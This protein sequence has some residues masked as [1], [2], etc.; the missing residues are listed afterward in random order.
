M[1]K[2][3]LSLAVAATLT[4]LVLPLAAPAATVDELAAQLEAMQA[5]ML[6]MQKEIKTLRAREA[7]SPQ[8]EVVETDYGEL[9]EE[10]MVL[11]EDVDDLDDRLMEPEKH[12][13][14]DRITWGG[15]FRFQAHGIKSQIPDY[16]DGMQMQ[17]QFVGALQGFGLLGEDFT[18]E[19][20]NAAVQQV[21][22]NFPPEVVDGM[23]QQFA[24]NAYQDGYDFDNDLIR[25]SRL[26]LDMDA[27]VGK[28]VKFFGRLG[29]YKVW[30]DSTGVQVFNGQPTSINWDGT[31]SSYPNSD[32]MIHVDRA[33][34]TW[35][36]IAGTGAFLSIGRRRPALFGCRISA[37]EGQR[38]AELACGVTPI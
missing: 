28:N 5:Q 2:S 4:G 10:V 35:S 32:D 24:E 18:Y 15:E 20:M 27:Q 22:Q 8:V 9:K 33:Y 30:G 17:S 21:R 36:R 1:K 6:D 13:A 25:T 23:M 14:I 7:A 19:E 11:R 26:R 38:R 3:T 29:M 34:F 16:I 12:A 37:S 31:Q